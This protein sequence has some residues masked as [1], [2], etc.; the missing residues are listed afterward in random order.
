MDE[1][2]NPRIPRFGRWTLEAI[3]SRCRRSRHRHGAY[4][5]LVA[6]DDTAAAKLKKRTLTNLYNE[7]PTWLKNSHCK[8]D[9]A[10]FAAY[11][12]PVA[13]SDDEL[14]AKLLALNLE[15]ANGQGEVTAN[16]EEET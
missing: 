15:K 5:R 14:L 7:M 3:R 4:P 6:K 16:A 2:G 9:E 1:D 10:V 8:L 11:G 13:L 12:W